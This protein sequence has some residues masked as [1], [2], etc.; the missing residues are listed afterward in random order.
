MH[1]FTAA[2]R[3][4]LLALLLCACSA[5]SDGADDEAVAEGE[6]LSGSPQAIDIGFNGGPDQFDSWPTYFGA[7]TQSHGAKLCHTYLAWNIADEPAVPA[8][9][10]S[11]PGR[12]A[13]FEAWAATAKK[14]GCDEALVSF[15]AK[16]HGAPPSENAFAAALKKF[17]ETPWGAPKL[18]IAPWNEPNN[19]ANDGDGLGKPIE[20]ELAARYYLS[21]ER[22]CRAHGCRAVAGDFASNGG[23]WNDFEWNCAPGDVEARDPSRCKNP[24]PLAN[25]KGPSYLDRYKAVIYDHADDYGLGSGFR[26]AVFAYHGWHDVNEYIA[27]NDHC[28]TYESC[29]TRRVLKNLGGSWGKVEIWDTEVGVGQFSPGPD[30][31]EQACAAAFLLRLHSKPSARIKRVYITRLHGGPG[32]LFDG[33]TPRE[34]MNVLAKRETQVAGCK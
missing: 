21:T 24:S 20:P 12:R 13:W 3:F 32:T 6:A 34:A 10:A 28:S 33:K 15:Q 2:R 8:D 5:S 18:A 14:A 26:P 22:L 4:S 23:F 19:G 29:A 17:L 7:E 25:G 9:A 31:K 16:A 1:L 11:E 30:P 27:T